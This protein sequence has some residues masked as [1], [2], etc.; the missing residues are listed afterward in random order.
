MTACHRLERASPHRPGTPAGNMPR[1]H[2]IGEFADLYDRQFGLLTRDQLE[3][4]VSPSTITRWVA[5]GTLIPVRRRVYRVAGFPDAWLSSVLSVVLSCG[6]STAASHRAAGRLHRQDGI[7]FGGVELTSR[8][9]RRAKTPGAV[10]HETFDLREGDLTEVSGVPCTTVVRTLIDLGAVVRPETVEQALDDALR[11]GLC[12]LQ[13]LEDRFNELARPGRNGIGVLR[14]FLEERL[15]KDLSPSTGFEQRMIRIVRAAGLP[16]PARQHRVELPGGGHAFL[17][18][19]WPEVSFAIECDD[20][21]THFAS[22][23]LRADDQRQNE[24][25]LLGWTLLRF[26]FHDVRDLPERT[27]AVAREGYR[28]AARLAA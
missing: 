27:A 24:I 7:R 9:G 23:R 18:L 4:R 13:Q 26:T 1:A 3:A 21:A 15:G 20:L 22:R 19:A 14:P 16:E 11:R 12:T 5:R 2:G 10:V 17:D 28:R 8:A 25:I 6:T